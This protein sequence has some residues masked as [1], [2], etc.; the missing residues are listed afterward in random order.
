MSHA[1][2]HATVLGDPTEAALVVAAKKVGLD[3]ERLQQEYPRLAEVPFD[4]LS[5]RMVTVHRGPSGAMF[6]YVKGS[7]GTLLRASGFEQHSGEAAPLSA[8][9]RERWE[10]ANREMGAAALRVLGLAYREL[11]QTYT[12]A[13][14]DEQL[15]FVGLVGLMDPLRDEAKTAIG[16][17]REAGVRIVMIT[18]DQQV[19]AAEIARQLGID[20]DANGREL[21]TIHARE[22]TGLDAEGWRR[23]VDSAAVFAR[24]SPEHKLRLVEALQ[25]RGNTVAMTGDGVNDAPALK[26]ADIGIA[27]G[28]K[29]TAVA[30]E[31]AAMVITD[32]NFATIVDAVEQGRIIYSNIVRFIHYLF[33]CNLSEILTVFVAIMV[34]W[35]LPLGAL[36]I[37]W[38]NLITDVFP[39]LALALEPSAPGVMQRGPRKVAEPLVT[40]SLLGIITVQGILLA[41]V[42]LTAFAVALHWYGTTGDGLRQATTIAFMTL[43]LTQ[44]AHVFNA[45]SLS[46]SVFT[47]RLFSNA[48]LWA[49][50][51]LCLSLQA[52]AIYFPPLRDLLDIAVPT[53]IDWLLIGICSMLPVAAIE[54]AKVI[55]RLRRS[56]SHDAGQPAAE[57][58]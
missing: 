39:A 49:A 30:K 6:A 14:F 15:V 32:D 37:L 10:T 54:I 36:Q 9:A 2:S 48:W 29:G 1:E 52:A 35:P 7:P 53:G 20:R 27:M 51:L 55:G 56:G 22:L 5:K 21:Q 11:P 33:S 58:S 50:V 18:G 17:C 4:S 24:V 8:E 28:I 40:M 16:R 57:R 43:T 19:T 26:R 38:M 42:T 12:E 3:R 45:R 34:G 46:R 44:I 25:Q 31:S 23:I 41:A 47:S 13:D